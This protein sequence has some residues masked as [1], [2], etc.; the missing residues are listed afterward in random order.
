MY[1]GNDVGEFAL[2]IF[3]AIWRNLG[4]KFEAEISKHLQNALEKLPFASLKADSIT[5]G[6]RSPWFRELKVY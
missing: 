3:G 2:G 6:K 4:H 5:L 1:Q